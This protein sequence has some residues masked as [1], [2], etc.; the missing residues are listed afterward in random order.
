M[1]RLG[2]GCRRRF[3]RF[4]A[5]GTVETGEGNGTLP[6]T[7]RATDL[8]CGGVRISAPALF[9]EGRQLLVRFRTPGG[10]LAREAEVAWAGVEV[11]GAANST[12]WPHGL[13]F[14]A[15]LPAATVLALAHVPAP[16]RATPEVPERT[17]PLD[18]VSLPDIPIAR[19]GL[20][21]RC[22]DPFPLGSL[23]HLR[24]LPPEGPAL[25]LAGRVVWANAGGHNPFPPGMGVQVI[26]CPPEE[27]ARLKAL[28]ERQ[29]VPGRPAMA[30][31]W[32]ALRPGQ[33]ARALP[34]RRCVL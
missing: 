22:P 11:G 24:L 15:P 19:G 3:P 12:G 7:S 23:V 17:V 1:E 27:A 4:P 2:Q 33:A 9:P 5:A 34:S 6:R 31:A 8:G 30:A 32:Y 18:A 20:F 13:R 26:E 28:L 10:A 29:A 25:H 16:G 21:V 14:L